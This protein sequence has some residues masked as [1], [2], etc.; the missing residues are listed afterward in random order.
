MTQTTGVPLKAQQG[1]T[2]I[3]VLVSLVILG[4]GLLGAAAIQLNAL[5][6]TD[7]SRISSQASFV[8]Y[9]MLDRIRANPLA[10]YSAPS[11]VGAM[12]GIAQQ[13]LDDFRRNILDFGGP[14]A[15]GSIAMNGPHVTINLKWDDARASHPGTAPLRSFVL[16]SRVAEAP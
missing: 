7:S 3:E 8:A 4:V 11:G 6:Y 12:S 5:K 9:D 13:D 2:L 15:T 16:T 10:D 14:T 1:M